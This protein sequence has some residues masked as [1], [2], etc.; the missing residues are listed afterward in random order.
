MLPR[1][2]AIQD[3]LLLLG[4][5]HT[6]LNENLAKPEVREAM[7]WLVDYSAIA[8]TIMKNELGILFAAMM[9]ARCVGWLRLWISA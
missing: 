4:L 7:K 6:V 5:I 9:R 2:H 8:D 3:A 1:F